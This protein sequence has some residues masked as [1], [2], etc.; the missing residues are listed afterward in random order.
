MIS[1]LQMPSLPG[2]LPTV[3]ERVSQWM[4][5]P[6]QWAFNEWATGAWWSSQPCLWLGCLCRKH[7]HHPHIDM[8]RGSTKCQMPHWPYPY[9]CILSWQNNPVRQFT[10]PID[11]EWLINT[12]RSGMERRVESP[13]WVLHLLIEYVLGSVWTLCLY[14]TR[15]DSSLVIISCTIQLHH[16]SH[17]ICLVLGVI[18]NPEMIYSIWKICVGHMQMS[19]HFLKIFYC[20]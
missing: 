16:Y 14:W 2:A 18:N 9:I 10:D 20:S 19:Y 12:Q 8:S 6:L 1:L 11:G 15:V 17:S 3:R 4:S 5:E 7:C 13:L